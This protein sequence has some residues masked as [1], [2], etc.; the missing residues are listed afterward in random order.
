MTDF[1]KVLPLAVVM[2][3]G[4]QMITAIM[5]VT[6]TKP[7]QNSYAF[8]GGAVLATAAATSIFYYVAK[9]L[10][11]KGSSQSSNSATVDWVLVVVLV[12][13]AIWTFR[14][15]EKSEPPKWMS[16]LQTETPRVSLRLGVVLF[17]VM[18]TDV[19]MTFTVGTYLAAHGSPL[20]HAAGFLLLTALLI[21]SPLLIL[22]LLGRRGDTL[23]PRMRD[24]MNANSWVVSEAVIAFF[25]LMEIKTIL[26]S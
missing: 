22:L 4:P 18:P 5:L 11:L 1:L 8:V 23:L 10:K 16:T 2:V 13:A 9:V 25:L 7:R 19:M 24:W 14:G 17:L 12:L 21:G 20:W 15:R 6:S 3:A 26:S